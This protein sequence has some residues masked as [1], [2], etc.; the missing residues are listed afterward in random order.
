[1]LASP[2]SSR[3]HDDTH[4]G[5]KWVVA[6]AMTDTMV[7]K[8]SSSSRTFFRTECSFSAKSTHTHAQA[9]AVAHMLR[10]CPPRAFGPLQQEQFVTCPSVVLWPWE[11]ARHQ[12]QECLMWATGSSQELPLTRQ[13]WEIRQA[14]RNIL[15]IRNVSLFKNLKGNVDLSLQLLLH[16]S[17]HTHI[18]Y[19]C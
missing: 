4:S 6:V 12:K 15:N 18:H 3:M 10:P 19:C 7:A 14:N 13:Q 16:S 1:M 9:M 2:G 8:T 17:Y 11:P 5:L